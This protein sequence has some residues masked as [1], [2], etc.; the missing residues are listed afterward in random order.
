[1][2]MNINNAPTDQHFSSVSFNAHSQSG[3]NALAMQSGASPDY[4]HQSHDFQQSTVRMYSPDG[5]EGGDDGQSMLGGV[6]SMRSAGQD[7]PDQ[8]GGQQSGDSGQS[9]DPMAQMMQMFGQMIGQV[10][11]QVLSAAT[12]GMSQALPALAG[13]A[14]GGGK[15]G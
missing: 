11:G 13:A 10:L 6:N 7:D 9:G 15:A 3:G 2:S 12:S 4:Q 1:M 8:A 5:A 14:M